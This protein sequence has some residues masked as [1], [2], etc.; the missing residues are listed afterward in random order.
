[1]V[2][3][4]KLFYSGFGGA[5]SGGGMFGTP[6]STGMFGS[7]QTQ[8]P[9]A[10]AT[11]MFGTPTTAFGTQNKPAFGFGATSTS[12]SLFGQSQTQPTQTSSLFGQPAAQPAAAGGSLFGSSPFGGGFGS[13]TTTGTTGTTI[14]FNPPAGT[15]SMVD[16]YF[17]CFKCFCLS[18]SWIIYLYR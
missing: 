2:C 6:A 16:T 15:D 5:T 4:L 14:K 7:T 1:M 12:N 17:A 10:G 9:A 3:G 8:T 11:G 18:N 13:S